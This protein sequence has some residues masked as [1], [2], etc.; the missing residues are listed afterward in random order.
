MG[1]G[2]A[3]LPS[4]LSEDR[5]HRRFGDF[6][7]RPAHPVTVSRPFHIGAHEVTNAQYEAFD[8]AHR[9][10]RGKLGFSAADDEAVVFVSWHEA[11]AFCRWLSDREGLPYRLPTEAE[12]E[13]VCRAGTRTPFAFGDA[14]PDAFHKNVRESWYPDATRSDG[15]A[16][17]VPL[18]VGQTP[19]NPW[20]VF[21]THGNVEEWCHDWYGPY[22]D[23]PQTDPVGR[24]GGDFR[25]T[26]GGSH[27]TQLYYLRS[28]NRSA[29]LPED[30]TWVIGFRVVIGEMPDTAPLPDL[31]PCIWQVDVHPGD[32]P[33]P[34]PSPA[35]P[36]SAFRAPHSS[37]P[38]FAPPRKFVHVDS[39][40]TGPLFPDHNH[41][42]ALA[43]CANGDLLALWYSCVTERGRELVVAA[44]RLRHGHD[45]WDAADCFWGTPDRNNHAPA[46]WADSDG[47]LYHFNGM[48]AAATWGALAT[49][50]RTSIDH[51]V[52]WSDARL[53]IPEH[54][55]RHM[56]VQTVFRAHD[57]A[58]LLPCDAV[59]GGSGGTAT[60]LSYDNGETWSDPGGT[61]A[62]IH[63]A[64]VQ[65]N[66]GRLMAF[67]RGDD[68]D[69][70]M[71]KSLSSDMGKTWTCQTGPFP[72]ISGGQRCVMLRLQE[73]PILF[74]SFLGSR[75]EAET[76][77]ITDASGAVRP[78]TGLFAALSF[79]EGETWSCRRLISDDGPGRELE[80][81]DGRPFTVG[82][83][84]A[85]PGGYISV[86]QSADGLIHLISSRLH[87]TFNLAWLKAPP[88]AEPVKRQT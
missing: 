42:T 61:A 31:P 33:G 83:S 88:P 10:L 8:P 71:P 27:S 55:P 47:T 69:G 5:P 65:L 79:D 36:P 70:R 21:D 49:V 66:D 40:A 2:D 68:I 25:V 3:P 78:V 80:T 24:A 86:C 16:E 15:N 53:I 58:I 63:A 87:Y 48:G 30:R 41:D 7:E 18:T 85:E 35:L 26:R 75:R 62:G 14:L 51:G 73:G 4:D 60:W 37:E 28:A 50:L 82:F 12:W 38:F 29:A 76:H 57:G 13:Y 56:P 52:T 1:A 64:V 84:S 6:D 59:T 54:G 34:R 9:E 23:G 39:D 81:M 19:A 77:E 74:L 17:V 32:A 72:P 45:E 43:A 11:E 44:S 22:A 46:L 67:G 20:G